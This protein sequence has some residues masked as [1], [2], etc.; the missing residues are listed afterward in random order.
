VRPVGGFAFGTVNPD[1]NLPP[2][3]AVGF[4]CGVDHVEAPALADALNP[5]GGFA[6]AR[7]AGGFAFDPVNPVGNLPPAGGAVSFAV[8]GWAGPAGSFAVAGWAGPAASFAFEAVK[9][10]GN[11]PLAGGACAAV[12]GV[13][14]AE[15]LALADAV[16][17]VGGFAVAGMAGGFA[18][19]DR[20]SADE[21]AREGAD[22]G[23]TGAEEAWPCGRGNPPDGAGYDVPRPYRLGRPCL[24]RP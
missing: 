16:N 19:A 24:G 8:A 1:G 5:V 6:V 12:G 3:G 9:A 18:F 10:I 20:A 22:E 17:P 21:G 14:D 11:R 2:A 15:A 7:W 13:E 23:M 4:V